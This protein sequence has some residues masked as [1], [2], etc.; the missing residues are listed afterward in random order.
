MV[1]YSGTSY[2][3]CG[4]SGVLPS[5][6]SLPPSLPSIHGLEM[7]QSELIYNLVLLLLCIFDVFNLCCMPL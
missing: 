2:S 6:P 7:G 1:V 3:L 5:P 4:L